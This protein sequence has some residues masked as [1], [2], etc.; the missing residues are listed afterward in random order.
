MFWH[1][2]A[3]VLGEA[4]ERLYCGHLCYGPP[5][6]DGFYYDMYM[7][8]CCDDSKTSG[9]TLANGPPSTVSKSHFSSIEQLMKKIC[10]EKQPFERLELTKDQLFKMF[11]YNMFKNRI[12]NEKV[13]EDRTT[14]YRCGTLID[15][16]LGPHI[17]NTSYIKALKIHK[18][19]NYTHTSYHT[20][21]S[22]NDFYSQASGSFW[23]GDPKAENLQRVYGIS[24]PSEKQLKEWVRI[25]EEAA[26]RDHRKIGREQELFFFHEFSKGSAFFSPKGA[27]IYNKL[28][29]F[30]RVFII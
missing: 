12:L 25:Q 7:K 20:Y 16:C 17:R 30:I 2:S 4:L 18:V 8:G 24:F 26:A 5:I 14:V 27:L 15:L 13:K 3:H 6:E 11:D 10:V 1:S 21:F 23:E 29:D 22:S 9:D 19:S 28:I